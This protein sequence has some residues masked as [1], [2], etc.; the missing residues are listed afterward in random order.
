MDPNN[1]QPINTQQTQQTD[2][3]AVLRAD[4]TPIA[5]TPPPSSPIPQTPK[6]G[7]KKTI[8]LLI[9]L[10]ILALGMWL[11]VL[12]VKNQMTNQQKASAGNT[13]IVTPTVTPIP[14]PTPATVD[15]INV[16]S[17]D[18]DLKGIENDIQGL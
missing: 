6:S 5:A 12:F 13:S 3:A 17:P 8:T 1:N 4:P 9:I 7:N 18:A 2:N 16:A 11:Y 10:I 15:E 14:T